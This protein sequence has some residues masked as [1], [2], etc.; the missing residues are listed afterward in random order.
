MHYQV[1]LFRAYKKEFSSDEVNLLRDCFD[2][3]ELTDDAK[4]VI[5]KVN[6]LVFEFN[7]LHLKFNLHQ[8]K[9]PEIWA[10]DGEEGTNQK[11]KQ[12][13]HSIHPGNID[14]ENVTKVTA[15]LNVSSRDDVQGSELLFKNW[16]LPVRVDNF[17][18]LQTDGT[19]ETQPTWINE[20]GTLI[21]F[22]SLEPYGFQHTTSGPAKRLKF[23]Y[24]GERFK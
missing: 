23:L 16:P 12:A 3:G 5:D 10:F 11:T 14:R 21:V 4:K 22:P 7:R 8:N 1:G 15:I 13:D 2:S 19:G 18:D 17:G 9:R 24:K 20:Q 6:H